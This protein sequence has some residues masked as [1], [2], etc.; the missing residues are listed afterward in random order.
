MPGYALMHLEE[1]GG[2]WGE[3]ACVSVRICAYVGECVC[4][5][6]GNSICLHSGLLST[7]CVLA[8][9]IACVRVFGRVHMRS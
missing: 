8:F 4:M 9:V 7:M 2:V 1:S 6:V 3:S 5:H